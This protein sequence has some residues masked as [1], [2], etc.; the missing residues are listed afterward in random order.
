VLWQVATVAHWTSPDTVPGPVAVWDAAWELWESGQFLDAL[1]VS[2]GRVLLGGAIGVT[3][4]L[5]LGVLS[6]F[7][8]RFETVVDAPVQAIRAVPFTALVP[9]FILWLGIGESPKVA[10]VAFAVVF[11]LYVNTYAGIRAVDAKYVEV[12]KVYGLN[13]WQIAR[14]V[15][16][17]GAL[18]NILVGLRYALTLAW[19]AVIV[20]EQLNASSGI[21]FLLVDARQFLR[22]DVM[23]VCL[24]LYAFLG[25]LTD[26]FLRLLER[27]VLAWRQ[28][29][30][31][32]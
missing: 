22:T 23:F 18:P 11:P 7:S 14:R 16:L 15:L 9:L 27:R 32:S 1:E 19:I 21:G 4:G 10:I 3:L 2:F 8:H 29:F 26:L 5:V 25:L 30:Q 28:G 12:A 31:G 17:P 24:A 13:R 6:G 20:A